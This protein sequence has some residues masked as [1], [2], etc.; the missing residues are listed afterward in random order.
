[1]QHSKEV[2][3]NVAVGQILSK[4]DVRSRSAARRVAEVRR[5]SASVETC[6]QRHFRRS[7]TTLAAAMKGQSWI[8]PRGPVIINPETRDDPERPYPKIE[9]VDSE[10]TNVEFATV[11]NF[12]D[13]S[14]APK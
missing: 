11:P 8:N 1:M 2:P 12:K 14:K 10:L 3:A 4:S 7:G 9:R 13:R 5:R 6:Y